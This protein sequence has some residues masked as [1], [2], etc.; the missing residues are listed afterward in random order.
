M[1][2]PVTIM[3]YKGNS[4][5]FFTKLALRFESSQLLTY[6]KISKKASYA[7]TS[8]KVIAFCNIDEQHAKSKVGGEAISNNIIVRPSFLFAQGTDQCKIALC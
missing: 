5:R 4:V 3:R 1:A 6:N 8:F 2:K 7:T